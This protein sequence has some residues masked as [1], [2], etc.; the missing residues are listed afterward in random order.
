MWSRGADHRFPW[1]AEPREHCGCRQ[2]TKT[3]RPPHGELLPTTTLRFSLSCSFRRSHCR[4]F[5]A[6][7]LVLVFTYLL[8]L[9]GR[10]RRRLRRRIVGTKVH[11]LPQGRDDL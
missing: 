9:V 2:T 1:S 7:F 6:V 11:Q 10:Q 8:I 3:D 4:G 5:G